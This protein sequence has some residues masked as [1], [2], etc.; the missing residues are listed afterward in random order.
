MAE[1]LA[2]AGNIESL[3]A[4]IAEGADAVYFGLKSFN[5][6]LRTSNFSWNQAEAAIEAVHKKHKKVYIT[7]NTV[8]EEKETERIYRLLHYIQNIGADAIIVQDFSIIRMCQEFFPDLHIHA[9]TQM[10]VESASAANLLSKEG[11]KRVVLARELSFDE[12][13]KIKQNTNIELEMFVHGALCVSESGL[14]LFSSF[15]G[16]KS[17]NRG[18]CTQACRRLYTAEYPEGEK[19]GYYFSPCDIQLIDHIPALI[20]IGINSFKI[21]GRMKSAEYV[22]SVVAAYRYMIDNC[23]KDK[24][25][26]IETAH[27]MLAS[28]FARSKTDYFYGFSDVS[29]AIENVGEK[30][31]N[32]DQAGG[33]GIFLG[34]IA[35][36]KKVGDI[37]LAHLSGVNGGNYDV[38]I[39]DSIRIHS[40]NDT[41]RVSHK[42]RSIE[43]ED[44]GK[45]Y[46]DVPLEADI[47]DS[48]YLLQIKMMSKRYP[49]VIQKDLSF[50]RKQPRDERLPILDLTKVKNGELKYFPDGLYVQVSSVQDI[51][52]SQGFH[53]VRLIIEY[54]SET[55]RV[56][57]D[58]KATLPFGKKAI[59]V[60]FDAFC[61]E[62]SEE[63]LASEIETLLE[64]GF[65]NFV[66]NNVAHI[67]MLKN[68]KANIIAGPFL[69]TF[70]R[71]A[72]SW[73]ENQNIDAFIMPY[74]NSRKNLE[75]TFDKNI[76]Q[77]VLVPIFAYPS[78]FRIRFKLPHNYDF[79]YFSDKED[80][81]FKALSSDDGSFVMPELPFSLLDKT[82]ILSVAGFSKFLI[83]FSKTK[84]TKQQ[85]RAIMASLSKKQI[86]PEVTRFNWKDGFYVNKDTKTTP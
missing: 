24:K 43:V 25:V 41:G 71:W 49:R 61:P 23:Q 28:D 14:C 59:F 63:K 35:N 74:E 31:L 51:F 19:T 13:K 86:L 70:N 83:D 45:N 60:S 69:Y 1:L 68:K 62:A 52:L 37:K 32:P 9:S 11:V 67:Q 47:G 18:M 75:A 7:L 66:A 2:P 44:D 8:F 80:T 78:L 53:P 10:N 77:K 81:T 72:V 84:I 30:V 4:A 76:R 64:N 33:T 65:V 79:T 29:G 39:G 27:R 58:K 17:A 56:L 15:L 26:A 16:G 22:G 12:I 40:K 85:I 73:L 55:K 54:N 34:K 36:I 5:A 50:F 21:E 42:V 3:D 46:I 82:D 48:V 57:L 6:R 20:D 38:E